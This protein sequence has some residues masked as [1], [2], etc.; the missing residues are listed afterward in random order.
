MIESSKETRAG[1]RARSAIDRRI[2]R[3]K[4][5]FIAQ[6]KKNPSISLA[7]EKV[8]I[9]RR[10]YYHWRENDK[11][12]ADAV[13]QAV[14]EGIALR[15]DFVESK[16]LSGIRDG[17]LRAIQ[18]WLRHHHLDYGAKVKVAKQVAVSELTPEQEAQIRKALQLAGLGDADLPPS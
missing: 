2:A 8:G 7:C 1:D 10:T 11:Q 9:G 6:M 13:D 14:I 4:S 12:F 18:F 3:E 15:N 17:N 16:L 5:Q